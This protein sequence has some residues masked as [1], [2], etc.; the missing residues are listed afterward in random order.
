LRQEPER[1]DDAKLRAFTPEVS[2][3]GA[4]RG[5][6]FG[7]M[8]SEML[9]SGWQE[10]LANLRAA[11]RHGI[12]VQAGTDSLMTGTFFG[13][14]LHWELEHFV[15]AGLTPLEVLR[16]ATL[17]AAEAVGADEHLGTLAEGKLAD[18]VLLDANPLDKIRHT[19]AIWRVI[20]DGWLFDPS[21]LRP[22]AATK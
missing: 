7:A 1:L 9:K 5:G 19:Q 4:R 6:L 15:E 21:E 13:A 20:K 10:R 17:G 3:S 12:K 14:S 16:L 18:L 11:H 8:P 22:S 2:I